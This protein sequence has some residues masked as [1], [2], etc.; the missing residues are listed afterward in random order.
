VKIIFHPTQYIARHFLVQNELTN[1][2]SDGGVVRKVAAAISETGL[3]GIHFKER[4]RQDASRRCRRDC[5][6]EA[7]L[8]FLANFPLG[9]RR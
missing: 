7:E 9:K 5:P 1:V 8:L 2:A 3:S 4:C 6:F